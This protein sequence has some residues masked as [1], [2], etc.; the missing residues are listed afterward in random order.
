MSDLPL[1]GGQ[2]DTSSQIQTVP[3][4]HAYNQWNRDYQHWDFNSPR[5]A[6]NRAIV[7][8]IW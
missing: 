6:K 2:E 3:V 7:P 8:K 4:V 5:Y 1:T